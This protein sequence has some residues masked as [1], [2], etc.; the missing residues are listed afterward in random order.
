MKPRTGAYEKKRS[1]DI[2]EAETHG[3]ALA[4]CGLLVVA[5][6]LIVLVLG[7]CVAAWA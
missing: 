2:D 7:L 3:D 6:A 5:G 4:G 1:F